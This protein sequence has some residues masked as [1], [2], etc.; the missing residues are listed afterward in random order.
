[1]KEARNQRLLQEYFLYYFYFPQQYR[2]QFVFLCVSGP[3]THKHKPVISIE[4][5]GHY[6]LKYSLPRTR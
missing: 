3:H 6:T 5:S 2:F 1:M 4:Q